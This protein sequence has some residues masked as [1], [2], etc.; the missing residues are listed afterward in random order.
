M[1]KRTVWKVC[2]R[3][4]RRRFSAT[5]TEVEGNEPRGGWEV[6]YIPGR[7]ARPQIEG[8]LLFAFATMEEAYEFKDR[9]Q[10]LEV[11]EAETDKTGRIT[12]CSNL[13]GN[14]HILSRFWRNDRE[15]IQCKSPPR[16]TIGCKEITLIK[17]LPK[18]L[19]KVSANG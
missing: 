18:K 12:T 5:T 3:I 13:I 15:E 17:K 6:E 14:V 8:S 19:P 4:G 10:Y 2:H 16:G 7:P 1:K 11:W 9:T